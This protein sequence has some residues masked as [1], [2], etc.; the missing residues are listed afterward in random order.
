MVSVGEIGAMQDALNAYVDSINRAKSA[1]DQLTAFD[2]PS[3][4]DRMNRIVSDM[5]ANLDKFKARR[6]DLINAADTDHEAIL[7]FVTDLRKLAGDIKLPEAMRTEAHS[8][9]VATITGTALV[10]T[11]KDLSIGFG[12][13][14][15]VA[16]VGVIL[17]LV[18]K[19]K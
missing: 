8:N 19:G 11:A 5:V 15:T 4:Y 2:M 17:Y 7:Q 18:I 6:N 13:T 16:V 12:I 3:E 10:N 1:R 14:A 9:D